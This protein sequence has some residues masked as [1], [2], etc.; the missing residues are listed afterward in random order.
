[1]LLLAFTVT[2]YIMAIKTVESAAKEKLAQIPEEDI[3]HTGWNI[4]EIQE[5]QKEIH[6]LERHL[7]LAKTDSLNLGINLTDSIVQ[8]QL[9][10][11]VLLNLSIMAH[12]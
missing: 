11:T 2:R 9:R 3:N 7:Q 4:P 10:G 6:W 1:V 5:K 8:V 12:I